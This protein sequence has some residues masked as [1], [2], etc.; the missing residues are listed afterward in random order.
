MGDFLRFLTLGLAVGAIYALIAQGLLLIYRGSGIVNFSQGALA[1]VGAF[2]YYKGIDDGGWPEPVAWFAA[3]AI[4]ALLGVL[5]Q[6]LVVARLRRASSLVRIVATLGLFFLIVAVAQ[7]LWSSDATPVQSPL[8]T[9]TR[10]LFGP[11]TGIAE[12]R[13]W[14]IGIA[15]V[16]TAGLS[17]FFRWA[18]FGLAIEAV[19][20]NSVAASA[21]GYSP[22]RIAIVTWAVGGALAAVAGI[23]VAPILFLSVGALAFMVLR[24]L[25]AALV[26]SFR[27]FWLTLAGALGIGAVESLLSRYL[28]DEG[29]FAPIVAEDGLVFGTFTPQSVYRS[30][31]FLLI[32]VLLVF[33]GRALPLRSEILDRLPAVGSGR[34]SPV[35][36]FGALAATVVVVMLVPADWALALAI[37]AAVAIICGSLVVVTGLVGQLSLAQMSLA[38]FGAWAAGRLMAAYDVPFE[39]AVPLGVLVTVP[40]GVLVALPA[41]RTRGINLAIVTFGLSIVISELILLN[42][43][44]TGGFEGTR[45]AAA[46]VFGIEVDA[47]NHP[48]RYAVLVVLALAAC[49]LLISNVRRSSVG[50]RMLAVRG[51]ERAAACLGVSVYGAKVFAFALAAGIAALGG[52]LLASRSVVF[53]FA[54]FGGFASIQVVVF[55]VIGGVGYV[56]G[57]LFAGQFAVNGIGA[58]VMEAIGLGDSA[59]EL[60]SGA[61]LL[62]ILFANPSGMAHANA[63]SVRRI[64]K[65]HSKPSAAP[66][67]GQMDVTPVRLEGAPL[68]VRDLTVAFGGVRAVDGVTLGVQ[69][70]QVVGLIGPNGA[71][72]TTL[73]DAVS[74]LVRAGRGSTVLLD[75]RDVSRWSPMR[76]ARAGL[77]RS[78][79]SVELFEDMT[80]RENL[81]VA[82]DDGSV[83]SYASGLLRGRVAKMPAVVAS[84]VQEMGLEPELDAYPDELSYGRR[85]IVGIARAIAATP[86]VLLLDEPAAGLSTH[87]SAELGQRIGRLARELGL[88]VLLIEHDVDMVMA[89][90]DRIVVLE[91]GRVIADGTPA[92]VARDPRV[93]AAYLG[94]TDA[95][96][97]A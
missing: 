13:L 22:N 32:V 11:G 27:S 55:T 5:T 26:G 52:I 89:T 60:I 16:V 30:V 31:S 47:L 76:R 62:V 6:V 28:L 73:V 87:E 80:V 75:G 51:N 63:E 15:I 17:A 18:R 33:R 46:S 42:A 70:G 29:L 91:F 82:A 65:R 37:S 61:L 94:D 10:E 84:V 9:T 97:V 53:S 85:R 69:P 43:A 95:A 23:L 71:G 78:F 86:R 25:A 66:Q 12:D 39:V 54:E 77:G 3:I 19:A 64:R 79:Q 96:G 93:V 48:N 92:E 74:G 72:K 1:M 38:G 41:L 21:L 7:E 44:V 2:V 88:A 49:L 45:P 50:L 56:A 58:Q 83:S 36:A 81:L 24:A 67:V 8:P 40:L 59:L 68:E 34:V 4:P 90:C 14:L 35:L 20:E 57:A